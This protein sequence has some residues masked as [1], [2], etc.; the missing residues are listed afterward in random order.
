MLKHKEPITEPVNFGSGREETIIDLANMIIE[1]SGKKGQIKPV[2][3]EPRIGE[4]KRLIANAARAKSLLGWEPTYAL[5]DGLRKFV[6]WYKDYG[7]EER[8]K[9]E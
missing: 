6:T 3:V 9:I 2:H 7:F 1:M 4:V 8:I 5:E